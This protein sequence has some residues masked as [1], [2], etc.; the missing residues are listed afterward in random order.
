VLQAVG[1]RIAARPAWTMSDAMQRLG[2]PEQGSPDAPPECAAI[3]RPYESVL[4][5]L[6]APQARAFRLLALADGPDIPLAAAA[7]ALN[8]PIAD[9]ARLLES[10]VDIHLLETG[11]LD[12]YYYQEP[13]R[14]F[15]R[16]RAQVDDESQAALTR[17]VRFYSSA[18]DRLPSGA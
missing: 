15:A 17:L 13:L 1:A 14:V 18:K 16:G 11:G 6:S 7:A 2:R 8:L 12:R 4:A 10:L 3:E 5:Q 9:T